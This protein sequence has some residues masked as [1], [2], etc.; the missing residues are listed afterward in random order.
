MYFA[1]SAVLSVVGFWYL[2]RFL[3]VVPNPVPVTG[4][5]A[6]GFSRTDIFLAGFLIVFFVGNVTSNWGKKQVFTSD[7]I[8]ASCVLYLVLILL[9]V[10]QLIARNRNPVR[11]FGLRWNL[12]RRE[13]PRVLLALLCIYPV[14][15][16]IQLVM[17]KIYGPESAPQEVLQFLI[18][19]PG[20]RERAMLA[21]LAVVVA[22]LAEETIFRGYIYGVVRQYLGRWPAILINSAVFALIHAHVPAVLGLFVLAVFLS[23]VYERTGSLW[24]TIMVH[25][26]FNAVTVVGTLVFPAP[27]P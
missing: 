4:P 14:I 11:L 24:S 22:P 17:E 2:A 7:L 1:I 26:I 21:V 20:W 3:T 6:G 19:S 23:L 27:M 25:A 9:L 15:I 5:A 12:W 10:G 16:L 8:L 13:I 18:N